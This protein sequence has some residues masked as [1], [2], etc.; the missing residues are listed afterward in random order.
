MTTIRIPDLLGALDQFR[1]AIYYDYEEILQAGEE[2]FARCATS[3]YVFIS[4][5]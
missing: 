2:W 5:L 4:N 3:V 1:T